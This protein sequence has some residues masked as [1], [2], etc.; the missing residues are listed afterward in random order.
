M[1]GDSAYDVQI[2]V[3]C[4][5]TYLYIHLFI[6]LF[7]LFFFFHY[8]NIEQKQASLRRAYAILYLL[9]QILSLRS[10]WVHIQGRS[11]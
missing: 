9:T 5:I 10:S 7:Y 6:Y 1:T 2:S 8:F 4:E 3:M 11:Q